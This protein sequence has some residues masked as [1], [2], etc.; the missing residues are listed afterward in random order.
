MAYMYPKSEEF[1]QVFQD[2]AALAGRP[3]DIRTTTDGPVPLGLVV[4][5]DLFER[6]QATLELPVEAETPKKRGPGRPRKEQS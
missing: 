6:Y 3:R 4:P 5:D 1:A 2:L